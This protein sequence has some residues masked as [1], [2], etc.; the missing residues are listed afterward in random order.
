VPSPE[1]LNQAF[2]QWLREE[3]AGADIEVNPRFG[4]LDLDQLSV[5]RV[6]STS[7]DTSCS[8]A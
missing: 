6:V 8:T 5:C 3:M 2:G 7:G 1:E 4:A